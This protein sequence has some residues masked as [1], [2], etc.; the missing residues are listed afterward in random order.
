MAGVREFNIEA[1]IR[2][3]VTLHFFH[4]ELS[5]S[6]NHSQNIPRQ[7]FVFQDQQ[8]LPQLAQVAAHA[9]Q[10]DIIWH[11]VKLEPLIY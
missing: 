7:T 8:G 10:L 5:L 4:S 9:V 1:N 6:V 3:P 11:E 2:E